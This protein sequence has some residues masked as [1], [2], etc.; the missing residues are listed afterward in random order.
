[1]DEEESI[2]KKAQK[3]KELKV[4]KR[5]GIRDGLSFTV[6]IDHDK[7]SFQSLITEAIKRN[8]SLGSFDKGQT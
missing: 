8:P 2:S 1:M 6:V 4:K 7:W 5:K 3:R